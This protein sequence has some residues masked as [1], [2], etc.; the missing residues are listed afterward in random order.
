[1]KSKVFISFIA[2]LMLL[3][4]C[5]EKDGETMKLNKTNV[6]LDKAFEYVKSSGGI[7]EYSCTLNDLAVLLM[8]DHSAP[9]VTFMVTYHVGSRNEAIGNTGSTHLLEHMMFKGTTNFN[10]EK[11]NDV[12]PMLQ[13]VG[14]QIN[15]TTWK[16]R[17]NYYELLPSEYLSRAVEIEADRMKYLL[18]RDED[19]Q[20]EMT[21]VRNEFEQGENDP[22]ESLEKNMWAT[23]YQA[24]PYHHSTIGWRSDI[25]GVSTERLR[26]FYETFYWP[27]NATVTIIGDFKK[28]EAL[29]LVLENFG[30]F[31]RS[32]E[33]I[34]EMYTTEPKQEGARR[35]IVRRTGQ[36]G[37]VGIAHKTPEGLH[38]DT[39]PIQI[40]AR[41]LAGGKS[42]RLYKK[43][44]DKGL[45]TS[46]SIF[47]NPFHDN[48]LF[49]TYAFLTPETKLEKI[50]KIILDE[51]EDI[52]KNGVRD[53]EVIR[54]KGQIRAEQAFS[55]DGSFSIASNLNEAIATGDW[56]FYTNFLTNID[57]VTPDDV[58]RVAENYLNEDQSTTGYFIPKEGSG[59]G[60]GEPQSI[61]GPKALM[62]A[63]E[64]IA[65]PEAGASGGTLIAEQIIDS[66]PLDGLRL[67]TMETGVEDVVTISGSFYGGDAYSPEG[68]FMIA[69]LTVAM[70][71]QGTKDKTK[72]EISEALETVGAR[73]SF[74]SDQYRVRF[75]AR[76][77]KDNVP[78]VLGLIA[79]Q[80]RE[81]A[82]KKSDLETVKKRYIGNLERAKESTRQQANRKFLQLLYPAGH[83]NYAHDVD[84]R[85]A[86][87]ESVTMRAIKDYH[88]SNYGL[89]NMTVVAVGDVNNAAFSKELMTA[90]SDWKQ[91]PLTLKENEYSANAVEST[92][93]YVTMKDKTSTDVYF[94]QPLGISR[95][96]E[97][98]YAIMMGTFIL[99]GNFSSRL[100]QTV[101][102]EQGLTYGV[103]GWLAGV[104]DGNDGFWNVW[105]A[106]APD[107][108]E[109]GR[110]ATEEQLNKW[111]NEGVTAE[112]LDAKKSTITGT[113]K[114]GLATTRGLA[115]QI[116]SN[117]ERG[118]ATSH[119]DNYPNVI[120]ALTLEQVNAAIRRYVDMDKAV[121]VAAGSVDAS[122]QPLEE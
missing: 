94:G 58:K 107:L 112:E 17:T 39:Y 49:I 88:K 84:A 59:G 33:P 25:E 64:T 68:N 56:T 117:A 47:D 36:N 95:D 81:P 24:H 96:H 53:D 114:V 46:L 6:P 75:S 3:A 80:L 122:G 2:G 78:L 40:L 26:E 101:R 70:L 72:F 89:G 51:Y 91:S 73:V 4:A 9:V 52:K 104:D 105:G 10:K 22:Y 19:R 21:V 42:S 38:K 106:F 82:F 8:E 28:D 90:F 121:F 16:D 54:V 61:P 44:V 83:P 29:K 93:T 45:A 35:V 71:D 69:D 11:G 102:A 13:D 87:V 66:I 60:G 116:L 7:D 62:T 31:P 109:Q 41:V 5:G 120:N 32:P 18:L 63:P 110:I 76:C 65:I 14:A 79:E 34:P 100:M 85:I 98:F 57:A 27:N 108:L 55:R 43:I 111:V 12:V 48:G 119:L 74:S 99:G 23:A 20:P 86:A 118:R 50:E 37:I 97:D 67:M 115:G 113:F 30:K 92:K 103:Y 77:L 15:A 1:M